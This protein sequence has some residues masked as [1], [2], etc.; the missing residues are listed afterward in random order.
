MNWKLE[1]VE[2]LRRY[3]AVRRAVINI[4]E[5]IA[6]LK[7][8]YTAIG[9]GLPE[10]LPGNRDER[11]REDRLMNN[12]VCRQEL[13]NALEQARQWMDTVSRAL[14]G[15]DPEERFVLHQ[16][17]ICPCTDAVE[18][19]CEKLELEKSSIYR[20]RD[21]ALQKFTIAMYG[22]VESN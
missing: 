16:M 10:L 11:K 2:K 15:L 20:R 1:A 5:E 3:D 7:A 21:K 14:S 18:H 13:Q 8:E 17:Y 4:P 12:I 22:C 6:R 9:A 19:L